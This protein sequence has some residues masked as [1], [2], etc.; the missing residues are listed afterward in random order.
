MSVTNSHQSSDSQTPEARRQRAADGLA[1][2]PTERTS[3]E[4]GQTPIPPR[5]RGQ[6]TEQIADLIAGRRSAAPEGEAKSG[7]ERREAERSPAD[8]ARSDDGRAGRD[9]SPGTRP[10]LE[11]DDDDDDAE[12][13]RKPKKKAARGIAEFAQELQL[14]PKEIYG[15]AV[16]GDDG[17]EPLTIGQMKDQL[18]AVRE[19]QAKVDQFEDDRAEAMNEVF[20]ARQ[21]IDDLLSRVKRVVTP[22]QFAAVFDD[23]EQTGRARLETA[24]KQVLEFFPEW[25][26]AAVMNAARARMTEKLGSYGFRPVEIDTLQDARMIKFVEDALRLKDRYDRV[27]AAK[28]LDIA[29]S[30]APS[31]RKQPRQSSQQAVD[32][33]VR[34]GDQIGAIAK[35]IEG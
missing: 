15:L 18:K 1:R 6:E 3:L 17:A 19:H 30:D 32:A 27:K 28:K 24:R 7:N 14:D 25:R 2:N 33:M 8:G 4:R 20:V 12:S 10:A 34:D 35:L 26:D 5:P 21:Q 9:A 29:S 11:L 31:G 13:G 22:Q 16:P 23:V